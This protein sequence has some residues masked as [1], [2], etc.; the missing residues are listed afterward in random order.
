M[1]KVGRRRRSGDRTRYDEGKGA[2]QDEA[3]T[4]CARRRSSALAPR[5]PLATS[6]KTHNS[7]ACPTVSAE[8][9]RGNF[10]LLLKNKVIVVPEPHELTDRSG[11]ILARRATVVNDKTAGRTALQTFDHRTPG[12][13]AVS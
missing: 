5:V 12:S 9:S 13:I 10:Y 8:G 1:G 4:K 7:N 3:G 2:D 6:L 11:G